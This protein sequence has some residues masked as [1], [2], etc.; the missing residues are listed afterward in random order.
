MLSVSVLIGPFLSVMAEAELTDA[1][2]ELARIAYR[3]GAGRRELQHDVRNDRGVC[4]LRRAPCGLRHRSHA[5][6]R[7][8]RRRA[9]V[10][11]ASSGRARREPRRAPFPSG[12]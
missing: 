6:V 1:R 2:E 7:D 5:G 12:G 4:L 11:T 8:L 3:G 10:R 9:L